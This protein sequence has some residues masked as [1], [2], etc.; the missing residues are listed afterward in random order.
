M[1]FMF[2]AMFILVPLFIG[3][4]FV[5]VI[6]SMIVGI[7]RNFAEWQTNNALPLLTVTAR[8]ATKRQH[9]SGGGND[10]MASTS[11]YATFE[12]VDEELRQEF[13]VSATDYSA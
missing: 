5:L 3:T 9:V 1:G 2:T 13:S 8:V 4:V 12:T 11:Y 10:T 7:F 6:G